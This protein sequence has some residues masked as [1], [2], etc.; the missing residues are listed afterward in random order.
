MLNEQL[1]YQKVHYQPPHPA[2]A[3]L[4]ETKLRNDVQEV[5]V[6]GTANDLLVAKAPAGG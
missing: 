3:M 5:L 4:S 2:D 1:E 6:N